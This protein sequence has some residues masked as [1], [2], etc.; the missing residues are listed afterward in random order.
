MTVVISVETG[1]VG[2]F[3]LKEGRHH[4]EP[5]EYIILPL[6]LLLFPLSF[7]FGH[8]NPFKSWKLSGADPSRVWWGD[9]GCCSCWYNFNF[10]FCCFGVFCFAES[11]MTIASM[12]CSVGFCTYRIPWY[13]VASVLLI[14]A[15]DGWSRVLS[16]SDYQLLGWGA[17][18]SII[19]VINGT[20]WFILMA[21]DVE[22]VTVG[23]FNQVLLAKGISLLHPDVFKPGPKTRCNSLRGYQGKASSLGQPWI[24]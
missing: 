22:V 7:L 6:L 10:L 5:L 17:G 9:R 4:T 8:C 14:N 11:D 3:A 23:R 21:G 1:V 18:H 13:I 20:F 16:G 19:R 15:L 24:C 12:S 2:L